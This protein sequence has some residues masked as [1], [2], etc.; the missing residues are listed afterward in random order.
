MNFVAFARTNLAF[1]SLFSLEIL[2]SIF[3]FGPISFLK[4]WLSCLDGVIVAATLALDVSLYATKSPAGHSASVL[5][6][7]PSELSETLKLIPSSLQCCT[8]HPSVLENPARSSCGCACVLKS[9]KNE[10]KRR[11][12]R[13]T[14]LAPSRYPRAP[15]SSY[16]QAEEGSSRR[17]YEG[18]SGREHP[19]LR[20]FS[21]L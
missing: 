5:F 4:S 21:I 1:L 12:G 20:E 10:E 7:S 15:L 16:A 13:L 11:V 17:S 14:S 2:L 6:S 8:C 18:E 9:L 19:T 3:A